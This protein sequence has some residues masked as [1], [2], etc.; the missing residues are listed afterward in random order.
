M[1]K[2]NYLEALENPNI[3]QKYLEWLVESSE[4][5]FPYVDEFKYITH[6]EAIKT[7]DRICRISE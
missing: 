1:K 5:N 6:E 7:K 3:R 4:L 2:I